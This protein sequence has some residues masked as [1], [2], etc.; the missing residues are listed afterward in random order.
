MCCNNII[1]AIIIHGTV[2]GVAECADLTTYCSTYKDGELSFANG[3]VDGNKVDGAGC[4]EQSLSQVQF[5]FTSKKT[6]GPVSVVNASYDPAT[7]TC[8]TTWID[9][10]HCV[11]KDNS[12]NLFTFQVSFTADVT[13]HPH[14]Y[15]ALV[16][17]CVPSGGSSAVPYTSDFSRCDPIVVQAGMSPF[18]PL[19][20]CLCLSL[21]SNLEVFV[22]L[23]CL[24]CQ[25]V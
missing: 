1:I 4:A 16:T 2:S 12:T 19:C 25:Y 14:Q 18:S 3:T 23:L 24:Y 22:Q 21:S 15:L 10:A 17:D 5:Q 8:N 13:T 7:G 9:N 11:S 6:N 20:L